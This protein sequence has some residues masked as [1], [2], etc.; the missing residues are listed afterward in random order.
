MAEN[1][2]NK[3]TD[4]H[5]MTWHEF[6]KVYYSGQDNIINKDLWALCAIYFSKH[7]LKLPSKFERLNQYYK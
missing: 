3:M 7:F 4:W 2:L 6:I 5:D 1:N